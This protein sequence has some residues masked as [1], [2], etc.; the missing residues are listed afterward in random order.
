MSEKAVGYYPTFNVP[1][2]KPFRYF[3]EVQFVS[4]VGGLYL[5]FIYWGYVQEKLTSTKYKTS[6]KNVTVEW[7]YPIALN[8]LMA[9]AAG[10][11]LL[12][13]I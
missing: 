10:E 1:A 4:Y 8:L 9:L 5:S 7:D 13:Y 12:I 2:K 3:K 6:E 11:S